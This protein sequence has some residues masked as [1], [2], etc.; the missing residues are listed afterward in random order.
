MGFEEKIRSFSPVFD[1]KQ[2]KNDIIRHMNIYC[3]LDE[4]DY[5]LDVKR[6]WLDDKKALVPKAYITHIK[7]KSLNIH[8]MKKQIFVPLAIALSISYQASAQWV[9]PATPALTGDIETDASVNNVYILNKLGVGV[10][11]G[12]SL[13]SYGLTVVGD[14]QVI[15]N[16]YLTGSDLGFHPNNNVTKNIVGNTDVNGSLKLLSKTTLT[17]GAGI[18]LFPDN[19]ST[20]PGFIEYVS[21]SSG[22]LSGDAVHNFLLDNGSGSPTS[23]FTLWRSGTASIGTTYNI[24]KLNVGGSIWMDGPLVWDAHLTHRSIMANSDQGLVLNG[25][26]HASDG[27]MMIINSNNTASGNSSGTARIVSGGPKP[28]NMTTPNPDIAFDILQYDG[29]AYTPHF[30][31]FKNGKTLIGDKNYL[32][33]TTTNYRLYVETGIITE[34]LKV[35]LISSTNWA[36]YVFDDSYSLNSLKDVEQFIKKNKHLPDVPSAEEVV[37]EGIDVATM[38]ATLLRKI[39]E[40][41]LYVIQ[42]QKEIDALKRQVKK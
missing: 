32:I 18:Q 40:L 39:E 31:V 29:G 19:H 1:L 8:F 7:L 33:N 21:N 6:L 4:K 13:G 10:P 20:K 3:S 22:G 27:A 5:S 30:T 24:A 9:T 28:A 2:I 11:T 37:K 14:A 16:S 23:L 12:M 26:T 34:K 36:D 41:T 25:K 38:D 35:T 17:N 42:Q 15:G